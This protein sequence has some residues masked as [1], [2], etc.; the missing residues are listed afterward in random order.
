MRESI[1][2]SRQNFWWCFF[3]CGIFWSF[4]A[5]MF[6]V[7]T[8]TRLIGKSLLKKRLMIEKTTLNI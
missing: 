1:S 4:F 5:G 7:K 2:G 6:L 3:I 8:G